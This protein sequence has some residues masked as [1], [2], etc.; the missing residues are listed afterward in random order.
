MGFRG[1]LASVGKWLRKRVESLD[2]FVDYV[3]A[4]YHRWHDYL[5]GELLVAPVI[6]WWMASSSENGP[7]IKLVIAAFVWAGLI[8]GYYAWRD[9]RLKNIVPRF[10]CW[11]PVMAL[12][13]GRLFVSI[14]ITNI[15]PPTSILSWQAGYR[16]AEGGRNWLTNE[17]FAGDDRILPPDAIR[18]TNLKGDYGRFETG[19][20]REGWLAMDVG[21]MATSDDARHILESVSIQFI[22]ALDDRPQEVPMLASW[23]KSKD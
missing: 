15:G 9:E 7:P 8:A 10:K 2:L 12:R 6:I 13:E 19:T 16:N 11:I 1:S 17:M 22:D 23:Q 5:W 21:P 18:G 3:Q 20:T 4:V 14:R